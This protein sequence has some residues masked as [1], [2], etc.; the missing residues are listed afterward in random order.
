MDYSRKILSDIIVYMK[1]AKYSQ[2]KQRRENWTEII[3][4][5]KE[6]HQKKFPLLFNEIE[7]AYQYVYDKKVLPSMRSL[8]FA[9]RPIELNPVRLFNCSYLPIDHYKAFAELCFLG[10]SGTGVG[11]SVQFHHVDKLPEIRIPTKTKRYLIGDSIE[12]WADSIKVLMKSYFTGSP[13]PVFDFRDIRSKGT[14]L[15]TS[16]GKAPGP[17]PLKEALFKIEMLLKNKPNGSK[18]RP[19]ECHRINCFIADAIA[20][21]GIRRAALIALFS[22]DDD[23]M[24]TCKFGK[25]YE[26]MPELARAN[27]SAVI[28]RNRILESEFKDLWYKIQASGAGEPGFF[29]TSDIEFGFNPCLSADTMVFVKDEKTNELFEIELQKLV[30]MYDNDE[31]LPLVVTYNIDTKEIEYCKITKAFLTKKLANLIELELENGTTIKLTPDH[32]VYTENRGWVSACNLD[33]NDTLI[34]KK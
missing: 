30:T 3:D 9:G 19:F 21:G 29:F 12:G 32:Q 27:N 22:F 7:E 25:W 24:L 4:R 33:E 5:N 26:D 10:L 6:M 15:V 13:A 28:L 14:R 20:S 2:E 8:Q 16:G 1:Y 23:E 11:Y 17:D 31:K 18:L 34:F